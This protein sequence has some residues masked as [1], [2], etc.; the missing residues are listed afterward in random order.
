MVGL[1]VLILG[2][3]VFTVQGSGNSL[4]SSAEVNKIGGLKIFDSTDKTMLGMNLGT[5]NTISSITLTFKTAIENTTV[6]ISLSDDDGL[7]IGSGSTDVTSSSTIVI[8]SLSDSITARER[9]TLQTV[10]IILS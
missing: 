3:I 7:E 10:S 9:V 6:N 8:I 5:A 2:I 4:E 1:V